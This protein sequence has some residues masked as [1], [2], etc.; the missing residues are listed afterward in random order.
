MSFF[1]PPSTTVV[2]LIC[3]CDLLIFQSNL[4]INYIYFIGRMLDVFFVNQ[5]QSGSRNVI[6]SYR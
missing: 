3:L 4:V 2:L 5:Q 1:F 6:V